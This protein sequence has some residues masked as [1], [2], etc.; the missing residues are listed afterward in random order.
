[1]TTVFRKTHASDFSTLVTEAGAAPLADAT[2]EPGFIDTSAH[3]LVTSASWTNTAGGDWG[4]GSNWSTHVP[5]NGST[6]ATIAAAGNYTVTTTTPLAKH[7]SLPLF[8]GGLGWG[9]R[10]R[11]KHSTESLAPRRHA[12]RPTPALHRPPP[13]PSPKAGEGEAGAPRASLGDRA[14]FV[15][16]HTRFG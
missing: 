16:A 2:A 11:A 13:Q 8:G 12:K 7:L 9:C 1:M 15:P 6:A 5:P 10:R 14:I 3:P 4:T